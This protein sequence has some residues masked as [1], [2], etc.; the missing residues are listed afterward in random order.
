L[1]EII[2]NSQL[3]KA[4]Q[5][6]LGEYIDCLQ[7]A[8]PGLFSGVYIEGSIALDA[9]NAYHSDIDF[10]ALTNHPVNDHH[11]KVLRSIHHTISA[12]YP[13]WQL[14]GRYIGWADL[15]KLD[16]S[17]AAYLNYHEGILRNQTG[18]CVDDV[19][20]WVLKNHGIVLIG[21]SPVE[22]PYNVDWDVLVARMYDNMNTYWRSFVTQ[23]GRMAWLYADYGIAWAVLGVLRQY[24]TFRENN[25]TSKEG[26]GDYALKHV[27]A[28]WQRII[29][30]AL[31]I[32]SKVG[33]SLYRLRLLRAIEA[34]R[35]LRYVINASEKRK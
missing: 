11:A 30:E 6:L 12:K 5:P 1:Q 23:P 15:A 22:L 35:F 31:N 21:P 24:Y 13:Q 34:V 9:F 33:H 10:I 4:I 18:F 25:I 29:R 17:R 8:L 2:T 27:P 32:R 28:R 19:D 3:P 20:W 7:Q 16:R 14:Q 26:A